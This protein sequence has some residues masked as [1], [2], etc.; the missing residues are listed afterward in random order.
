MGEHVTEE[1]AAAFAL[2]LLD[3]GARMDGPDDILKSTPLA[4][5]YR[6]SRAGVTTCCWTE[7]RIPGRRMPSRGRGQERGRRRWDAPACWQ[8]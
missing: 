8:Y 3:A 6:W 1:E 2:A 7:A 4:W 5:A